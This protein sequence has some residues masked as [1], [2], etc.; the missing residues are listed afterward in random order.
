NQNLAACAALWSVHRLT[1]HSRWQEAFRRKWART[2]EHQNHEGWFVEYGGADLGYS[3]LALDLLAALYRLGCTD[4][5]RPATTLS[6]F[7]RPFAFGADVA[8]RLGSR[9]TDH[10]FAFGAEAL[11]GVL[12]DASAV[13]AALRGALGTGQVDDPRTVDDRY[14][15]Y[16]YLPSFVLA[17]SVAGPLPSATAAPDTPEWSDSGF[18]IWRRSDGDV[19]CSARRCAAFNLY[20]SPHPVHRNLGYWIETADGRRFATNTWSTA[21]GRLAGSDEQQITVEAAAVRVEDQLPLVRHEVPFR[22]VSQ[23]IFRWPSLAERF[24][25]FIKRRKITR[26]AAG[27]VVLRRE[28]RWSGNTLVV[29][30]R[31]TSSGTLEL[32]AIQPVSQIDVHSPSARM[33]GAAREHS[34]RVAHDTGKEWARD[35][36]R[37]GSLTLVTT[38]GPGADGRLRF[39]TIEKEIDSTPR[40]R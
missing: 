8:G 25:R 20:A 33:G 23:Y 26:Q 2:L 22:A 27:P 28:L 40:R 5:L 31:L 6:R 36:N 14:L 1:G 7:I 18:R 4:A 30:D 16:F 3:L 17:A 38:Y 24:H 15:A 12:P 10:S 19:V 29:R 34:I 35:L 21:A 13:A 39:M 37:S 32:T 11:A 9:G